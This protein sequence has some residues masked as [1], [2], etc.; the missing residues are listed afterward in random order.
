MANITLG[1]YAPYNSFIHRMDPRNKIICLILLMVA[2]FF[3]YTNP[4]KTTNWIVTFIM[5]GA[6]LVFTIILLIISHVSFRQIFSSLKSLWFVVIFLLLINCII[7]PKG[8]SMIA[9]TIK[10]FN[11]Y[12]EAIFQ[13]LKIILRLVLMLSLTMILTATTK[14]LDLTYALEWFMTPLKVIRF[15]AH[16]IAMTISIALRF[17]PT[18]LDETE[19]I[20]KA[21]ESRGVDFKHGRIS[22]RFKAIIS[23]IVPLFISAFQRSEELADAMEARGYDPR[24]KR[25]RYRKLRFHFGDFFAFILCGAIMS[26]IIIVSHYQ[27]NIDTYLF[28]PILSVIGCGIVFYI[29]LLGAIDANVRNFQ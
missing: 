13:S 6:L 18:L 24:A 21:Q 26:G 9:F 10:D 14:P 2:I 29:I 27:F 22:S 11:V 16:E 23:L 12:W 25:T 19:R 7:P 3:Q 4:D 28:I 15:P 20:M 1:R 17:I 5:G 8:A